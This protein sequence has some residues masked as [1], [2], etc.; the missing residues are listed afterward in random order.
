MKHRWAVKSMSMVSCSALLAGVLSAPLTQ[1]AYADTAP[2]ATSF[3]YLFRGWGYA[4]N[5]GQHNGNR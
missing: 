1:I 3:F 5:M 2:A 4:A